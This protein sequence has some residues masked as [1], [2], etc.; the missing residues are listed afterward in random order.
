MFFNGNTETDLACEN[1]RDDRKGKMENTYTEMGTKIIKTTFDPTKRNGLLPR[2]AYFGLQCG[3]LWEMTEEKAYCASLLTAS[4][5]RKLLENAMRM[6]EA[7]SVLVIGIGNRHIT[8]DSI[9]PLCADRTTVRQKATASAP[10]VC[11]L[12]PGVCGQTGINTS[13][14]VS[15]AVCATGADL[16][17][18]I[19]SL[20]ASKANRLGAYIQIGNC[21]IEPGS[22]TDKRGKGIN[23]ATVGV[24]VISVGIPT[25]IGCTVLNDERYSASE[26][27]L[28]SKECDVIADTGASILANAIN[29][30]LETF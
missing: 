20:K 7:K 9:G 8:A 10:Q 30:A 1:S 3:A 4:K 14:L 26:I 19:D 24:P 29:T 28:T 23:L 17:I 21:G 11:V 15:S 27:I 12:S 18:A 6:K 22:G 13:D 5:I 2:D 16:V 25:V